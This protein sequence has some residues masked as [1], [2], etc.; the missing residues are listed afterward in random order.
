MVDMVTTMVTSLFQVA[1]ECGH[2]G[3]YGNHGNHYGNITISGGCGM[4]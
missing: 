4:W 1:V 2:H 3:N